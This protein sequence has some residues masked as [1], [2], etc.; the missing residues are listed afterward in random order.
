[1][2]FKYNKSQNCRWCACGLNKTTL[3]LISKTNHT[4][5][6]KSSLTSFADSFVLGKVYCRTYWRG[7]EIPE[8]NED[9][10]PLI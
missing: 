10:M 2:I 5:K 4:N 3:K 8:L 6:G 9:D 1:M 7:L